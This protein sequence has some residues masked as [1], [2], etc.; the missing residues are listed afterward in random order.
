MHFRKV[1]VPIDTSLGPLYRAA[2]TSPRALIAYAEDNEEDREQAASMPRLPTIR[3]Y[4]VPG[5]AGH[6][7]V[8]QA[9]SQGLFPKMLNWLL[10][11]TID[12][13]RTYQ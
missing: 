6:N 3:L 5:Y 13:G 12:F 9:V 7:V 1:G 11:D 2:E 10:E 8:I 4:P